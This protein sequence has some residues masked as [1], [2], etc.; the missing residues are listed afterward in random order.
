MR[1]RGARERGSARWPAVLAPGLAA[2]RYEVLPLPGVLDQTGTLPAG[3]TVT[4]TASPSRGL[5]ATVA[6]CEKLAAQRLRAV[7]HLAA[8][9][10]R[11]RAHLHELLDRLAGAE[12]D[13]IFVVAGDAAQPA[14]PFADGLTLLREIEDSGRRPRRVGVPCYPEGHPAIPERRLWAALLAKQR[15]ADYAVSQLCFDAAVV[16]RFLDTARERGVRLPVLVGLAGVVDA[17]TL[18]RVGS[19]IG[20]GDSLAFVRANRAAVAA[21]VRPARY[22]PERFLSELGARVAAGARAPGGLHFYTF[23]RVTATAEW[24]AA[25]RAPG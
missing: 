11:D 19:R 23:N 3:T 15:H 6:L 9:Q 10:I 13:E 8:R 22:R 17:A 21:L 16:C 25:T 24:V 14:G 1:V 4:V 2:P 7:A 20:V 18:L 12:L 5:D